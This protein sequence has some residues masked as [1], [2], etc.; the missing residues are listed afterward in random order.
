VGGWVVN[1]TPRPLRPP[2]RTRYPLYMRLG[3]PQSRSGQV[4]KNSPPPGFDPRT[5]Q[6]VASRYTV[7]DIPAPTCNLNFVYFNINLFLQEQR[8]K[9]LITL[10]TNHAARDK[11]F[12]CIFTG[13]LSLIFSCYGNNTYLWKENRKIENLEICCHFKHSDERAVVLRA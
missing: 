12:S 8:G 3:G 10:G 11:I 4:R 2:G 9:R 7:Y 13:K 1:A 5:V 6:P